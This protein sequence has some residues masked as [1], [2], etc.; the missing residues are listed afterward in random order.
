MTCIESNFKIFKIIFWVIFSSLAIGLEFMYR[1]PLFRLSLEWTKE[2]QK[3]IDTKFF[4]IISHLGTLPAFLPIFIILFLY[5][6]LIKSYT[7]INVIVA[8]SFITN[9]MKIYYSNPRP[10]WVEPSILKQCSAGYGNPSGHASESV[11]VYL[12]LWKILANSD[13]FKRRN[14]LKYILLIFI[15]VLL[16]LIAF[17]RVYLGVHSVNQVIFGSTIGFS[18]YFLFMEIIQMDRIEPKTFFFIFKSFKINLLF[19]FFHLILITGLVLV[20]LFKQVDN[21]QYTLTLNDIC[22]D[23]KIANRYS[24]DGLIKGFMIAI[25]I[26]SHYGIVFLC[27][28]LKQKYKDREEEINNW[29][30][31]GCKIKKQVMKVILFGSLG[32]IAVT[33]F[34]ISSDNELL[35]LCLFKIFVPLI[36]CMF[37][38]YGIGIYLCIKSKLANPKLYETIACPLLKDNESIKSE[39]KQTI[40]LNIN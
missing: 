17:S 30:D 4:S 31:I 35:I 13:I 11:V 15:L 3:H 32:I 9:N 25:H 38:I 33:Y 26:G 27:Y 28:F 1:E 34:L 22:P 23:M 39:H 16:I 36:I 18:M 24:N 6:P 7:F 12:T 21:S 29:H 19:L 40:L 14:L 8:V 37:N 5:F 2:I 10:Y 20:W